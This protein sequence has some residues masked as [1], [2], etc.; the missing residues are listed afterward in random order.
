MKYKTPKI[1]TLSGSMK[2]W[3]EFLK[4]GAML[5]N[6][7]YIVLIPF[8]E[9]LSPSFNGEISKDMELV[10]LNLH[11][12]RIDVSDELFVINKDGYIGDSTRKEIE[13]AKHLAGIK[14]NYLEPI[15]KEN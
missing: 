7:G 4:V 9:T 5:S 8:N 13:Y 3:D 1:V 10:L 6:R 15:E 2:F 12:R 11:K 14:I